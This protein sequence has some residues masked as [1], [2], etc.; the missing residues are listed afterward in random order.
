MSPIGAAYGR[1]PNPY[2]YQGALSASETLRAEA[3]EAGTSAIQK[4][5]NHE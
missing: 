5:T 4:G 2:L 1:I 3:I